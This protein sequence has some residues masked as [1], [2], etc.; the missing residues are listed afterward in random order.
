MIK[1]T[2]IQILINWIVCFVGIA[3][4]YLTLSGKVRFGLGL[5]DIVYH[6]ALP[7]LVLIQIVLLLVLKG[8]KKK[9]V[10]FILMVMFAFIY[11]YFSYAMTLGRGAE[12]A[13]NGKIFVG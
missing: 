7:T 3:L 12:C 5:G 13:W 9:K 4:S 10:N 8:Y 11:L 6:V 2:Q 1:N